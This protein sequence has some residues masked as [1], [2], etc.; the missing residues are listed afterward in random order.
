MP[1]WELSE[2]LLAGQDFWHSFG[3]A[4]CLEPDSNVKREMSELLGKTLENPSCGQLPPWFAM[5]GWHSFDVIT[6]SPWKVLWENGPIPLTNP[7]SDQAHGLSTARTETGLR[8]RRLHP[9][10]T[11]V[12]CALVC[13]YEKREFIFVAKV[14]TALCREIGKSSSR[15]SRRCKL[16]SIHSGICPRKGPR[17]GRIFN[18]RGNGA[19]PLGHPE[20]GV[21]A[22]LPFPTA[23]RRSANKRP[24]AGQ[25]KRPGGR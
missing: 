20:A 21:P 5:R 19:M 11:L 18:R 2:C 24:D 9:W 17:A 3:R 15:R 23:N 16:R 1:D 14:I 13:V 6:T 4:I 25:K 12:R 8:H 7:A 10:S 22:R